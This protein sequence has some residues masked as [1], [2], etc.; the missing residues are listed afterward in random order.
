M[1][2]TIPDEDG[3]RKICGEASKLHRVGQVERALTLLKSLGSM[4]K[5]TS[6]QAEAIFR[7]LGMTC[8]NLGDFLEARKWLVKATRSNPSSEAASAGLFLSCRKLNDATGAINEARRYLTL[9]PNSSYWGLGAAFVLLGGELFNRN[10]YASASKW[11]AKAIQLSPKSELASLLLFRCY[12]NTKD[13]VKAFEESCR[14][15]KMV[16]DSDYGGGKKMLEEMQ[17]GRTHQKM[18]LGADKREEKRAKRNVK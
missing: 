7:V 17:Q 1:A 18:G 6:P 4:V 16:P 2:R 8:F 3:I 13:Y 9:F 12:W 10:D 11:L 15:L 14:F 5:D